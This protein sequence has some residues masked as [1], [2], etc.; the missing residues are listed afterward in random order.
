MSKIKTYPVDANGNMLEYDGYLYGATK[1][2]EKDIVEFEETMTFQHYTKGRSSLRFILKDSKDKE[3][4][5]M[6]Q[7]IDCFVKQSV[8]GVLS[9]KWIM[10]K[11]G[12]N[13]G[14]LIVEGEED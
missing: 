13:Y 11:R 5:M 8:K 4:S 10:C 12:Q 2:S 9:G 1:Y 6:A 14:L 3:W 7:C